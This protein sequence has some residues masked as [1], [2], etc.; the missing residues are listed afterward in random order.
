MAFSK[1]FFF[2]VI[3]KLHFYRRK[4]CSFPFLKERRSALSICYRYSHIHRPSR[5]FTQ[6]HAPAFTFSNVPNSIRGY[7]RIWCEQ[8]LV[9]KLYMILLFWLSSASNQRYTLDKPKLNSVGTCEY[10]RDLSAVSCEHLDHLLVVVWL[11]L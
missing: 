5:S 4:I 10:F 8:E 11:K 2:R 7:F 9:I 6:S 3:L 1:A